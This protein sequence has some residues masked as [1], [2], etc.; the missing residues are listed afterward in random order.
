VAAS[1]TPN[2]ARLEALYEVSRALTSSLDLGEALLIVIDAAIRLTGAERGFLMLCDPDTGALDFRAARTAEHETIDES[3]FEVSRTVVTEVIHTGD[4]V[5]TLNAQKDPRFV[6]KTS[7]VNYLLR[8]IM[9]VP[10]RARGRL[11]GVLYVDSRTRDVVFSSGDLDLLNTFADQAATAIVNA[12]LFEAQKRDAEVRHVLLEIARMAQAASTIA[13]LAERLV[14]A[15]PGWTG[16]ERCCLFLGDPQTSGLRP[17]ACSRAEDRAF[18]AQATPF[19]LDQIAWV[20]QVRQADRPLLLPLTE[21][22]DSLPALWLQQLQPAGAV[23]LVPIRA[24][25]RLIGLLTLDNPATGQP[26]SRLGQAVTD[27]LGE[28]LATALQRLELY[29]AS[30]RQLQEL[31]VLNAVA[32]ATTTAGSLAELTTQVMGIINSVLG[33]EGLGV[34]LIDEAAGALRLQTSHPADAIAVPLGQGIVG[35]VAATGQPRRAPDVQLD[36][37]YLSLTAAT[38]SELCVPLKVGERVVGVINA[39]SSVE[40]AFSAADERLL[41]TVADQ[42]AVAIEK[43][44]LLADERQQRELAEALRDVGLD[45]TLE[46]DLDEVLNRLLGHIARVIPYDAASVLHVTPEGLTTVVG[47]RGYDRFGPEVEAAIPRLQF[48]VTDT[49][50]LRQMVETGRPHF[51][52][53]VQADRTWIHTVATPLLRAWVGAPVFAQGRCVAFLSAESA[54]PGAYRAEHAQRLGAFAGYAALALENVRLFRAAKQQAAELDAVRT[55]SLS[56]TSS[57][58]VRAVLNA[59]LQSALALLPGSQDAVIYFYENSRLILGAGLRADGRPTAATEPRPHGLTHTVARLGEPIVVADIASHPLFREAPLTWRGAIF[60]LPLKIGERVVGVMNASY[61]APRRFA[62]GEL[63]ILKLLGEQAAAAIENARLF[64]ATRKQVEEL[65]FLQA[66]ALAGTESVGLDALLERVTVMIGQL[67]NARHYGVLLLDQT[68]LVLQPHASFRGANIAPVVVGE[69]LVGRVATSGRSGRL[70]PPGAAERLRDP[71]H[72]GMRSQLAVPLKAGERVIGVIE[73]ESDQ[74][75]AFN[76]DDERLLA[77]VAGQLATAMEKARLFDAERAARGQAETLREVA[78]LLNTTL[79]R[80]QLL[81]LILEQLARL[82]KY[83]SASVMLLNGDVLYL[84]A[85]RGFRGEA[86]YLDSLQL[87]GLE[88]IRTVLDD[89][90]PLMI[91]DTHSD[92]RWQPVPNGDYI[93]CWLGVPLVAKGRS[94]GILNLDSEQTGFYTAHDAE[95]ALALANQAAVA[96]ERLRLLEETQQRERELSILL[97]IAQAVSSSLNLEEILRRVG[98]AVTQTLAVDSCAIS[99][100]DLTARTVA[101]LNW[102]SVGPPPG[103]VVEGSFDLAAYP[104]TARVI[105]DDDLGVVHADDTAADPTEVALLRRI[106]YGTL[107]MVA[108]RAS[109]RPVGLLEL[110]TLATDR[111]FSDVDL[112]LA[113]AIADQMGVALENARLFQAER[114]QRQLAEAL[115]EA[116][117]SLSASLDLDTL[118]DQLL[119]RIASVVPYDAANLMLVDP[120][121]EQAWVVRQRGYERFG[122]EAAATIQTVRLHIGQTATLR[123][124]MEAGRAMVIAD[125]ADYPGWVDVGPLA[126]VRS[127]AGAPVLGQGNVFAFINLDKTEAGFYQPK[128]AERLA[129]FAGQVALALQN[130]R[131]FEA[132]RRRVAALTTLHDVGLELGVQLDLPSL[133]V[134]MVAGAARLLE[135]RGGA[136]YALDAATEV[137]SIVAE[138][139]LP[140]G[141]L[142]TS[143]RVGEDVAGRV[144]QTEEALL[145]GDYAAQYG[146]GPA[147]A[148]S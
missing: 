61:P 57:L 33:T 38:R 87:L 54:Q 95:V 52:P 135:T 134:S 20:A 130:A 28:Q 119:D 109:G 43:Q 58:D 86:Q 123:G 143:L 31:A 47:A 24:A 104:I 18:F 49:A 50:N 78:A 131:L 146:G 66:V 46:A 11:L 5:V 63:R 7:I 65:T 128:H 3:A 75:A 121:S 94:I 141:G 112:R 84:A 89:G 77:T 124:L 60:G 29:E 21:L 108:V 2:H 138:H 110:Y 41:T 16:C 133:L 17:A 27:V 19:P 26:I 23:L 117:T 114:E 8:S 139:G 98:T 127:W 25:D 144:A 85:Q 96:L 39:E 56:L 140:A 102:H 97:A 125:V 92:D 105:D 100:V 45:L 82:V 53:D 74:W 90:Q 137:L 40:D 37:L 14:A 9:A 101:L 55:A 62:D 118:L 34:M 120:F 129:A 15:L 30:R 72:R 145:V 12:Q 79:D 136:F 80:A 70:P 122:P 107:L 6:D 116:A 99:A 73:A 32:A 103:E 115:R 4:P 126:Q 93:R 1:L 111:E 48:S 81:G 44:R 10:L 113:R 35:Y 68:G 59:I 64:A 69:G 36:P 147:R 142:P 22:I 42:L 51:V 132:E 13:E 88:H 71:L 91:A 76:E 83:Q 106:G 148:A 67:F